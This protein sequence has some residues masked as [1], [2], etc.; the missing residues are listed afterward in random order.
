MAAKGEKVGDVSLVRLNGQTIPGGWKEVCRYSVAKDADLSSREVVEA[1]ATKDADSGTYSLVCTFSGASGSSGGSSSSSG[2]GKSKQ[3]DITKT[4]SGIKACGDDSCSTGMY[5][6]RNKQ[7]SA[8]LALG[9]EESMLTSR[10]IQMSHDYF[11]SCG[12]DGKS[13]S[14]S[15]TTVDCKAMHDSMLQRAKEMNSQIEAARKAMPK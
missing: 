3:S 6:L 15:T 1:S 14:S 7:P 4:W 8:S 11:Q 10:F 12:P 5:V 2:S 9:E 13:N